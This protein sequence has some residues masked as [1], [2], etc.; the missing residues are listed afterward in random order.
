MPW[1]AEDPPIGHIDLA[2]R[3]SWCESNDPEFTAK[4][5]DVVGLYVDPLAKAKAGA[6]PP[7]RSSLE[8]VFT[9]EQVL[10]DI[11]IYLVTNTMGTGLDAL[12]LD[13]RPGSF[14]QVDGPDRLRFASALKFECK[15]AAACFGAKLQHRAQHENATRRPFLVLGTT[16]ANGGSRAAVFSRAAGLS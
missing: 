14:G 16:R 13:R 7:T 1:P 12:R 6:I 3:K 9:K 11:M 2:A 8:P 10:A 4:A 5:A 15:P